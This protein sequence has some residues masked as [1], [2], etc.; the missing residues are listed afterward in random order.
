M[1]PVSPQKEPISFDRNVRKPGAAFLQARPNPTSEEFR[2]KNFWNRCLED[3]QSAYNNICAYSACWIPSDQTVDHFQP[4]SQF[5]A[6]AYEWSNYRL[7]CSKVNN[8]K[9]NKIGILDPFTIQTGWFVLD[10][11][12]FYVHPGTGLKKALVR[13][14][15]H[16]ITALELNKKW[17]VNWRFNV[18]RDYSREIVTLTFLRDRYPFLASE[19]LRQGREKSILG[20][21]K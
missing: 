19:L 1:I 4:R 14:I 12:S 7:A 10:C 17:L 2:K 3:L 9:A 20:T 15:E 11:A 18:A 13:Q 21:M 8:A 6:L 5:P 16:T